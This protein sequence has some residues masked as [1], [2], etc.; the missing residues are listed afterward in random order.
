MK[1]IHYKEEPGQTYPSD[2]AKGATGRVVI[3]QA[4]GQPSFCMRVFEIEPGGFSARHSHEYEHQVFVH[5]GQGQI[6]NGGGWGELGPGTI[7]YIP[8]GEEHQLKSTGDEALVF[9][10]CVPAG[11][12]EL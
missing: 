6:W 5:A 4:D 1:L 11:A 3:G 9:V 10:C 2:L 7:V 8:G 12:P